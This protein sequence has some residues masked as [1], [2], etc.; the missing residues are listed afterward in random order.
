MTWRP[1]GPGEYFGRHFPASRLS[2]GQGRAG[3]SYR[4]SRYGS[5]SPS[6]SPSCWSGP[7]EVRPTHSV[8]SQAV[9]KPRS[10]HSADDPD[11]LPRPWLFTPWKSAP[12][13]ARGTRSGQGP[14]ECLLFFPRPRRISKL[15]VLGTPRTRSRVIVFFVA[16]S[17]VR[18]ARISERSRNIGSPERAILVARRIPPRAC[19]FTIPRSSLHAREP[20]EQQR[21]PQR[22][23]LSRCCSTTR[24]AHAH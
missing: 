22:R 19:G 14:V 12:R 18:Q 1:G 20:G 9:L 3:G 21:A 23:N 16:F 6:P 8:N 10:A 7:R 17:G 2:P 24:L 4:D 11:R 15:S 5:V 13:V